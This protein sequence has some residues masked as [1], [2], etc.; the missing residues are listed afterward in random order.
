MTWGMKGEMAL[1]SRFMTLFFDKMAGP[2]FEKGILSKEPPDVVDEFGYTTLVPATDGDGNDIGG[3]RAPMVEAP[4]ATY[5]GWNLRARGFGE[6]AKY[7]F[8]DST[9]FENQKIYLMSQAASDINLSFIIDPEP[10]SQS[11]KIEFGGATDF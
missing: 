7:K 9:I 4:L 10:Q 2:D 3:V 6:G 1:F 11:N 5:T 8:S